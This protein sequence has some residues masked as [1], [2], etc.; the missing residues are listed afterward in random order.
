IYHGEIVITDKLVEI[1]SAVM[2]NTKIPLPYYFWA[3]L[4]RI[5]WIRNHASQPEMRR[6]TLERINSI[7]DVILEEKD[8]DIIIVSH[9]GTL[10]EIQRILLKKGFRGDRFLKAKNGKLY[11]FEK[12]Q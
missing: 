5:A 12:Q 6:E 2:M 9:A 10:Y 1:P 7:L 11:V 4:S 8:K 3:I